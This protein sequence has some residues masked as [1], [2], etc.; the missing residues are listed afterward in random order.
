MF[1]LEIIY[2]NFFEYTFRKNSI[3]LQTFKIKYAFDMKKRCE[4]GKVSIFLY[5]P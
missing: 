1:Y 5:C 2:S 3:L 4:T